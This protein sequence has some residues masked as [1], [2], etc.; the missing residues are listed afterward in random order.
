MPEQTRME[1][2]LVLVKP[3][4]VTRGLIGEVA[5]RIE[6]RGLKIVGLKL[7]RAQRALVEEHYAEH[8]GKGFYEDVC[9]YLCSGP[10]VAMAVAG[11]NAV[12]AIRTMMGATNPVDAAP[13]TVRGDLAHTMSDNVTHSSSDPEAAAREV[14][15]WFPEGLCQ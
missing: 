7:L 11:E 2:T 8:K 14:A 13:G 12:L 3:G 6:T 5:R 4:G 10:I 15:I 1:T 9:G